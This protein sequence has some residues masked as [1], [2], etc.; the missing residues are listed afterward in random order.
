MC[1]AGVIA[2]GEKECGGYH[3]PAFMS[4]K[5]LHA[6]VKGLYM[7]A[8]DRPTKSEMWPP[9][10]KSLPSARNECPLQKNVVIGLAEARHALVGGI[11]GVAAGHPRWVDAIAKALPDHHLP[12]GQHVG[13]DREVGQRR[14]ER[15]L[16]DDIGRLRGARRG[17]K[18]QPDQDDDGENEDRM[19]GRHELG[20]R[21]Q[22]EDPKRKVMGVMIVPLAQ[23]NYPWMLLAPN[24]LVFDAGISATTRYLNTSGTG[25]WTGV[26][27]RVGGVRDYGS[28]GDVRARQGPGDGR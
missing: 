14:D 24:G 16:P 19:S 15:P 2:T 26:A 21:N 1:R 5:L 23:D 22:A 4:G 9:A 12:R 6:L 28:G 20:H 3:R 10:T 11:P 17:A 8:R 13:V 27:N 25:T 7:L 18:A